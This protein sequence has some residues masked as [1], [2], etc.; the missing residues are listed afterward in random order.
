MWIS[1]CNKYILIMTSYTLKFSTKQTRR[2]KGEGFDWRN[3]NLFFFPPV[4]MLLPEF[5]VFLSR[6]KCLLFLPKHIHVCT[7]VFCKLLRDSLQ[8]LLV[9]TEQPSPVWSFCLNSWG[10]ASAGSSYL[11]QEGAGGLLLSSTL[12]ELLLALILIVPLLSYLSSL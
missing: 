9:F 6:K 12:Q 8:S 1:K 4:L 5:R 3:K 10:A 7:L 11:L 2:Y